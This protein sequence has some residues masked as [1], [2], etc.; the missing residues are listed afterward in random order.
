[1]CALQQAGALVAALLRCRSAVIAVLKFNTWR[2]N[3]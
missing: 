3:R 2:T 1:M